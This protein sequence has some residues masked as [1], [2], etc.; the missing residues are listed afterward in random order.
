LREL[1][2]FK[3]ISAVFDPLTAARN[4]LGV[5]PE[6]S[7]GAMSEALQSYVTGG[8]ELDVLRVE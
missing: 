6:E 7:R 8:V 5:C 1:L 4:L 3:A 2:A